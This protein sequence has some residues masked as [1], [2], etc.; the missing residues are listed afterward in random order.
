MSQPEQNNKNKGE[1]I[2]IENESLTDEFYI[3]DVIDN[4][5]HRV[6]DIED[7]AHD[8]MT[9]ATNKY[10]ENAERLKESLS[11]CQDIL[12][13]EEDENKK[14]LGVKGIRNAIREVDR[15][16]NSSPVATL[17]KSLFIYLFAAFDKFIGDL[18]EV[19]Y[20][21]NPALYKNINREISLSEALKYETMDELKIEILNKEIETIRRKSY[22]EQFNDLEK[23]FSIKLTKFDDWP[24]FIECS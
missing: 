21:S 15:H 4:F 10:N 16:N 17:E 20:K 3:N 12:K 7:C 19:V 8:F 23:K 9:I 6:L 2:V 22:V 13:N 1:D 24:Y 18:I 5:L 11:E 14:L